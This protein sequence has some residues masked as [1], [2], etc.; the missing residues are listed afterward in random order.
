M[1][2]LEFQPDLPQWAKKLVVFDLETTGLDLT[3]SRIVTACVAVIDSSGEVEQTNEWLVNP[4]IEIPASASAVHGVTTEKA[5][6][7]GMDASS[8]VKQIVELL[9]DL[10]QNLPVVAFNAPYDFTIL[11]NEAIRYSLN[12]ISPKPVID[13][14][15]I[16]RKLRFGPGKRNLTV[17]C[18]VYGVELADAHNSTADAVAAGRLAQRQAAK[19]PDLQQDASKLHDLQIKWSEA[20]TK[21]FHDW[22]EKENRPVD[23]AEIGWPIRS[24]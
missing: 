1:L 5:Q 20:W 22:L 18:D 21:N 3:T 12:T 16:D 17:L 14:L 4:G 19:F 7:E 8:A 11:M 15:V 9:S 24:S 23:R 13:P 10:N 2:D 6:S